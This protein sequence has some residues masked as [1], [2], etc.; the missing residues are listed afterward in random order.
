MQNLWCLMLTFAYVLVALN[1]LWSFECYCRVASSLF[2]STIVG[3]RDRLF[4]ATPHNKFT[5]VSELKDD[6]LHVCR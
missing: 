5:C 4:S 6:N 3:I 1:F 2:D